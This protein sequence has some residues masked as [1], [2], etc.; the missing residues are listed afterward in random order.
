MPRPGPALNLSGLYAR[1]YELP[2]TC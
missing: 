2:F 1:C